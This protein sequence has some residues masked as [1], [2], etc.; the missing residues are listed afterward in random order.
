MANI[1]CR[2]EVKI[3]YDEERESVSLVSLE[4]PVRDEY[5]Q[6]SGRSL[7]E[8]DWLR[9]FDWS[10]NELNF[11]SHLDRTTEFEVIG[12][13]QGDHESQV[14]CVTTDAPLNALAQANTRMTDDSREFYGEFVLFNGKLIATASQV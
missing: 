4:L 13:F 11:E 7:S 2:V 3:S 14:L 12:R 10:R 5:R 6:I 9:V 1:E 8:R